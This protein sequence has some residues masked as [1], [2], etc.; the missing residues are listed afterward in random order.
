MYRSTEMSEGALVF[1]SSYSNNDSLYVPSCA[2]SFIG[3]TTFEAATS[4]RN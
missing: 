1:P 3:T 4:P 2:L